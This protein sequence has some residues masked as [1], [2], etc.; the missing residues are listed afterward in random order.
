VINNGDTIIGWLRRMTYLDSALQKSVGESSAQTLTERAGLLGELVCLAASA[1]N[2]NRPWMV[3][4]VGV[5]QSDSRAGHDFSLSSD[6]C[7][8]FATESPDL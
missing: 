5:Y 4:H 8:S 1:V 2:E 7:R 3:S 6:S